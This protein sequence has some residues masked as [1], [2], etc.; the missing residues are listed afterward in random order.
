MSLRDY[1]DQ[2]VTAFR[3]DAAA[4]GLEPVEETPRATDEANLR[5]MTSM[6]ASLGE[7]GHTYTSDGSVYF[8]I[9]SFPTYG[10]LARLDHEGI[11]SG[12]RVDADTYTKQDAR[13]FVLWKAPSRESRP[14]TTAAARPSRL[15]HR[16]LGDGA[17]PARRSADRHS[18]RRHRPDLPA[19]RERNRPVRRRDRAARSSGSGCTSSSSTS[20]TRRCRSRSGTSTPCATSSIRASGRRRCGIC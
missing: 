5:A 12:A 19:P 1:T 10:K 20:T 8:R 18:R 6:I 15:A 11:Q 3:E 2:F 16:V 13:D 7:R 14:G 4:M 9:A 17:P